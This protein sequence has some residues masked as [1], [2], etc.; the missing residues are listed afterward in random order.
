MIRRLLEG[1]EKSEESI[2][3]LLNN[4]ELKYIR[5]IL[6]ELLEEQV[7]NE[8]RNSKRTDKRHEESLEIYEDSLGYLIAFS[9]KD[10]NQRR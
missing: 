8:Q 10:I 9:C 1:V 4:S 5:D 7:K 6:V 3:E 2:Q